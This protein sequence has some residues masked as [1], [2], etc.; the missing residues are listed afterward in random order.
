MKAFLSCLVN[1][2]TRIHS[3]NWIVQSSD[4]DL[5]VLIR[6]LDMPAEATCSVGEYV[7]GEDDLPTCLEH[8]DDTWVDDFLHP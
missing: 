5:E 1:M 4:H 3:M 6:Q 2:R 8:D 7:N